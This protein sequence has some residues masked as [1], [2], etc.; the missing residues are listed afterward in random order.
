MI[1]QQSNC[2]RGNPEILIN[3]SLTYKNKNLYLAT[4]IYCF[5]ML[6]FVLNFFCFCF[7]L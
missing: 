7:I 6:G 1:Q 2:F 5:K 4:L 3:Q